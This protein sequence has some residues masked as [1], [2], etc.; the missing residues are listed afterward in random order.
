MLTLALSFHSWRSLVR[1]SEV[2][3]GEGAEAMVS[4]RQR[5]LSDETKEGG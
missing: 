5:G 1:G 3:S 2:T 4:G